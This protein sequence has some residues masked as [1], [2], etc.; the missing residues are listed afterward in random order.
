MFNSVLGL[1]KPL[2]DTLQTKQLNLATAIDLVDS[3][4]L[5]LKERRSD[6]Y[7]EDDLWK[8]SVT[9]AQSMNIDVTTP[10]ARKRRSKSPKALQKGVIM[11]SI[12]AR[13][14]QDD[15][16][17]SKDTMKYWIKLSMN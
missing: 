12:G 6:K 5:T 8:Q 3:T 13:A 9:L 10:C 11:S 17:I 16:P 1:T 14:E 7:F 15:S 2:S 4:C